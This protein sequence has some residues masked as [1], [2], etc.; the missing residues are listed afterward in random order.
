M[1]QA[2][3]V[4]AEQ[5]EITDESINIWLQCNNLKMQLTFSMI[6]L[7]TIPYN[8]HFHSTTLDLQ[9]K[10]IVVAPYPLLNQTTC[11][12]VTYSIVMIR[13]RPIQVL[14]WRQTGFA[15]DQSQIYGRD[16][17]DKDKIVELLL[18]LGQDHDGLFVYPIVGLGGLG[19]TTLAQLVFNDPRMHDLV[20][21]LAQSVTGTECY[22]MKD[23]DV[24]NLPRS[25]ILY[26]FALRLE[27]RGMECVEYIDDDESYDGVES[28]EVLA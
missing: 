8:L 22:V 9:T 1:I 16:N 18:G 11:G 6:F 25:N 4:D 28:I 15:I 21:D 24:T 3:I 23:E 14:E 7:K 5:K 20:H 27:I 13:E 2:V 12:F 17:G 10:Y 26:R 19:K